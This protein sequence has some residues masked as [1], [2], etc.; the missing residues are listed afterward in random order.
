MDGGAPAEGGGLQG[1]LQG[2]GDDDFGFFLELGDFGGKSGGLLLSEG[3]ERGIG[4]C[5]SVSIAGFGIE[6]ISKKSH[7]CSRDRHC[8]RPGRGE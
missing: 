7:C 4:D 8:A 2:R 3:S 6:V 1:A 5:C